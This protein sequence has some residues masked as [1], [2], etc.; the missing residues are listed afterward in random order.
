MAYTFQ[1]AVDAAD[2][3]TLAD[4]WAETLGWVVEET[5][6]SFIDRMIAEGYASEDDTVEHRGRR[7]WR[8]AAAIQHPDDSGPQ[9]RR[10]LFQ[11]VP[12]PKSVKNRMHLDVHT[13]DPDAVRAQ[14]ERRGARYVDTRSQGPDHWHVML[15]PEGNEFCVA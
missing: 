1:V 9:R 15:D 5:D 2:A 6:E 10:V 12:E 11:D 7:V 4:W 13:P 14:L 8:G 3:L